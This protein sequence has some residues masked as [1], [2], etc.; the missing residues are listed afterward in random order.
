MLCGVTLLPNVDGKRLRRLCWLQ[1]LLPYNLSELL[2]SPQSFMGHAMP[3]Q[4]F[5]QAAEHVLVSGIL[6]QQLAQLQLCLH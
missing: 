4:Q 3:M 6:G 1:T 2:I 5:H